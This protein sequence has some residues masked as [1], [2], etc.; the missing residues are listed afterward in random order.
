MESAGVNAVNLVL[1][2]K[3]SRPPGKPGGRVDFRQKR[4]AYFFFAVFLAGAAALALAAALTA[5]WAATR[6]AIGTR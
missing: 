5:A 2:G 4:T 3:K 6:R 1:P